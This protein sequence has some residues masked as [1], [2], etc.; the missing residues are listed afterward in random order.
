MVWD[1]LIKEEKIARLTI[2][3]SD[4]YTS[5]LVLVTSGGFRRWEKA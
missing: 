5:R 1:V 2:T 3:S 4:H